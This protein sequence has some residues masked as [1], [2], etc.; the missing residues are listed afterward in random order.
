MK[1]DVYGIG[2]P[3]IDINV[4]IT[5]EELSSLNIEKGIMH[6]I[7]EDKAKIIQK[8]LENK[9]PT[10]Y[11]AGS[12]AN[13][14]M[15]IAR[16]GGIVSYG[17]KLGSDDNAKIY[18]KALKNCHVI[19]SL[20]FDEGITGS[21]TI[22]VTPDGERTMNTFLGNCQ[23]FS[24]SDVDTELILNSKYLYLTG[25]MWDTKN[26]KEA[27]LFAMDFAKKNNVKIAFNLADPFL[28]N[29]NKNDFLDLI[30][31]YVDLI[32]ANEE[33]AKTLF[34][35]DAIEAL[36]LLGKKCD[37]AVITRGNKGSIAAHK[38]SIIKMGAFKVDPVDSTGAGDMF[39]AG[40]LYGIC[41]NMTIADSMQLGS[42]FA[43]WIVSRWGVRLE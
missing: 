37:I 28:V 16:L 43:S 25:Y 31:R 24:K 36:S 26:Q 38:D 22:F 13:T 40:L 32:I 18:E 19:S 33:E 5:D 35:T 11:P 20:S 14:I 10:K 12:C 42:F 29:R 17:G 27:A 1:N 4:K 34:D 9:K 23:K 6:L 7:D 21:S 8:F 2:N 30:S 41:K 3:L 39:A 15:G